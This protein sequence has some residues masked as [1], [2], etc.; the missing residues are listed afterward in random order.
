MI[1]RWVFRKIQTLKDGKRVG[2]LELSGIFNINVDGLGNI[3]TH[4]FVYS[5]C[6]K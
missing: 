4:T 5:T 1:A 3:V 2:A 6:M